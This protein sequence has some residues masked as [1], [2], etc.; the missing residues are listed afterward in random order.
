MAD[1]KLEAIHNQHMEERARA[2][3]AQDTRELAKRSAEFV[4]TP[5]PACLSSHRT[6]A[7]TI[8]G[9][10]HQR[11][12]ECRTLYI[13]PCP[14][15]A[16]ILEFL[17]TSEGL[18]IWR[19]EMPAETRASRK[20]RLYPMR[21]KTALE[22]AQRAGVTLR[23]VIEVGGGNGEFAEEVARTGAFE[24]LIVAEPQPLEINLPGVEVV[25][26]SFEEIDIAE[27]ADAVLAFEVFEHLVEP[28]RFLVFARRNLKPGGLLFM[29][30]PNAEGFEPATMGAKSYTIP[31]DHVRLYNPVALDKALR[32]NGFDV[33]FIETP[34][35]LDVQMVA[36]A[37]EGGELDL[38]A[39]PALRYI[40]E[41]D[42]ERLGAFQAFLRRNLLSGHMRCAATP[43]P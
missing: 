19:E 42:S 32:R 25:A 38:S 37:Y 28:D 27:K 7:Y 35:E 21:L 12:E 36:R 20:A 17:K 30:T 9:M 16:H 5:C 22:A 10:Q 6:L 18:R 24:R 26:G 8:N 23:H 41:G 13:S 33:L 4:D 34:G 1:S 43:S 39:N 40:L 15:D 14:T 2:A 11:C 29:T 31:F 3:L